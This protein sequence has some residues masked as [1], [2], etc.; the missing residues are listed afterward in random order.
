MTTNPAPWLGHPTAIPR[1]NY[2]ARGHLGTYSCRNRDGK[3]Q[4][5]HRDPT[6]PHNIH[7][8]RVLKD[9]EPEQIAAVLRTDPAG[10]IAY[11]L[12]ISRDDVVREDSQQ[13]TRTKP[14]QRGGYTNTHSIA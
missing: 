7:G 3:I 14:G 8:P 1:H 5:L 11:A 2:V 10:L 12:D 6:N 4:V 13:P 9:Y